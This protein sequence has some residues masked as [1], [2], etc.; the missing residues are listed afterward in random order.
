[1]TRDQIQENH[2]IQIFLFKIKNR[3]LNKFNR[4]IFHKSFKKKLI[5]TEESLSTE[6]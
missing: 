5:N 2:Q 6:T 3:K 1:M 4:I